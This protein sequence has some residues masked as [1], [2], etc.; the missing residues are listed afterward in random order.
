MNA[1]TGGSSGRLLRFA[2]VAVAA[3]TTAAWLGGPISEWS[4]MQTVCNPHSAC[5]KFQLDAG[6]AD[7]LAQHAISL[8]TFV[9]SMMAIQVAQWAVWIGVS[10]LIIFRK[11]DD[12]G[13]LLAAFFL[14]ALPAWSLT[15]WA[16]SSLVSGAVNAV[17]S[18]LLLVFCLLFPNG[19]FEPPWTCWLAAG[20]VVFDVMSDLPLSA[21]FS[22]VFNLV[23]LVLIVIVLA[24]T[25]YRYRAV[26]S[27]AQRQQTKWAVF[28]LA[29]ALA[30]LV[31]IVAVWLSAPFPTGSGSLFFAILNIV[32][33]AT[34]LSAIPVSIGIAVFR[35]RLWDI[36]HVV[37]RALVYSTLTVVLAGL[38]VG[39]ILGLEALFNLIIGR[40]SALA[41][42]IST[43]TIAALFNPLR[44][45]IQVEIDRR[46]YR[47]KYD[48]ERTLT[49]FAERI[50]DEVDLAQIAQGLTDVVRDTLQPEHVSLWLRRGHDVGLGK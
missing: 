28:G 48:A 1:S 26:S 20:V 33:Y 13:A 38:Y 41:I 19:R 34:V 17:C 31:A 29:L 21:I 2:W 15:S 8:N 6:A 42:A 49:A 30:G 45:R 40:S 37:N 12:R 24:V 3:G 16:T 39:G 50:R 23:F 36:D 18:S 5:R 43:I 14:A 11:A 10:A 35:S 9:V 25:V 27:W 4:M 46:F 47:S 44:R 7:T 22:N 32:G